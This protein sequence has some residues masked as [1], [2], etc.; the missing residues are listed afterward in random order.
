MRIGAPDPGFLRPDEF[1]AFTD[2]TGA[3]KMER[4]MDDAATSGVAGTEPAS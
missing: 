3:D 4:A 1:S 2:R